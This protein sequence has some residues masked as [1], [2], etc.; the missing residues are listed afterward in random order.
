MSAKKS[1]SEGS[2][3]AVLTLIRVLVPGETDVLDPELEEAHYSDWKPK[4]AKVRRGHSGSTA[5]MSGPPTVAFV[6]DSAEA[7]EKPGWARLLLALFSV[8]V[9]TY[10][11]PATLKFF[12]AQH[13][14]PWFSVILPGDLAG[15]LWLATYFRKR[16]SGL[17]L[18][19]LLTASESC[20]YG[21]DMVDADS[22]VWL[23]DLV[24]AIYVA[25]VTTRFGRGA[26]V[27]DAQ[28]AIAE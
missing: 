15:C 16:S 26:R 2:G 22:L 21:F 25:A 10:V 9:F 17:L 14:S 4:K 3:G 1:N 8:T 7:F 18:Y 11:L 13:L 12:A 6:Q 23:S 28:F 20:L 24:P 19:V 5:V 27:K